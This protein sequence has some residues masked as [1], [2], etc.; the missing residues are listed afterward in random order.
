MGG[1]W[2]ERRGAWRERAAA[3]GAGGEEG[4]GLAGELGSRGE[5]RSRPHPTWRAHDLGG[6]RRPRL[7][8]RTPLPGRTTLPPSPPEDGSDW[9]IKEAD[10]PPRASEGWS[11]A[12]VGLFSAAVLEPGKGDWGGMGGNYAPPSHPR[13]QHRGTPPRAHPGIFVSRRPARP[14]GGPQG[15]A[16]GQSGASTRSFP[17]Y[18]FAA[19]SM[20]WW[21]RCHD[22]VR[23]RR[24][25]RHLK[26]DAPPPGAIRSGGPPGEPRGGRDEPA[27]T[28]PRAEVQVAETCL[29][30]GLG[31]RKRDTRVRGVSPECH[32]FGGE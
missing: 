24:C 15:N 30:R 7:G 12:L 31:I 28:G 14:G 22:S 29:G 20:P 4:S 21:T 16:P 5:L 25:A 32:S 3:Q 11:K 6:G 17:G 8:G 18:H 10:F 19:P 13:L 23:N 27:R 26:R 2:R 1:A 9:L